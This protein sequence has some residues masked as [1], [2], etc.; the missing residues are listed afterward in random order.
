MAGL[1]ARFRAI[2]LAFACLTALAAQAQNPASNGFSVVEGLGLPAVDTGA[3]RGEPRSV[4][5]PRTMRRAALS[6]AIS[7][8]ARVGPSGAVY[9]PGRV[10]VKFR[11]GAS[12][13]VSTQSLRSVSATAALST[14]PD[15]ADFDIMT[16]AAAEDPQRVAATLRERADVEWAQPAYYMHTNFVP[17]D[18]YYKE[19]QWNLPLINIERAWDIQPAAGSSITVAVIDTG[20]AYTNATITTNI[21]G[22]R[23]RLGTYPPIRNA[24]IPYAAATQLVTPGRIVAP[25]D[26]V[27]D[28]NV[29][30]PLDFDGHGT[31]VSGTIGQLTND[32]MSEAGVAFNVKLMPLKALCAEW[33]VLF[34]TPEARCNTDDNVAQAIRY[35]ADNGAKVINMSIGRDS[36][37]TC[38]TNRNQPDCAPAIEDAMNY[39]VGK[40]VFIAIAAGNSFAE[41]NPTQ[42][43]AEI[44]SRIKGAVSVAAVGMFKE[45]APYSSS[46]SW[47]ELAAPGGIGG[48]N[49]LGYVWQ[50]TFNN[51]FTDTFELPP[52][53]YREPRFDILADIGYAGTSQATP[54]VSGVAALLMQQGLTDPAAVEAVLEKFAIDLGAT[55][56]D[57]LFGYG[58]IDAR[59]SLFGLGLAR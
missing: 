2:P 9:A 26:F 20:L 49:D 47:V 22:F 44:A 29:N 48:S 59:N 36:P 31:H 23:G 37:A 32:G 27:N 1:R 15:Y 57:D 5:T 17:N 25:H 51:R 18:R 46:G 14:R 43:P 24:N 6:T 54:H 13:T 10:L 52:S 8:T 35:A 3:L 40:G 39:A 21:F 58:L 55:G 19:L 7:S 28:N 53:L 12:G 42:T 16:I 41:G 38:G 50:Q 56:R 34:G 30:T 4:N 11:G 45:H 33:D